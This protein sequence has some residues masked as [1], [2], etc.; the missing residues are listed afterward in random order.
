MQEKGYKDNNV[1]MEIEDDI[2]KIS[3]RTKVE[4]DEQVNLLSQD[5]QKVLLDKG[6]IKSTDD[7]LEQSIT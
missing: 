7:V 5:I 2:T 6:Y 4:K 1:S 3:L